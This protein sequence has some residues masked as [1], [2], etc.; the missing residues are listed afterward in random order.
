MEL[1]GVG[2]FSKFGSFSIQNK[3]PLACRVASSASYGV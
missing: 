3:P 2:K 1:P